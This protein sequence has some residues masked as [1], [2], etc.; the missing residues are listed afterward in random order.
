MPSHM[1]GPL[2]NLI[3][4]KM[5]SCKKQYNIIND[6]HNFKQLKEF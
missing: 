6:N 1:L 2:K 4:R 5:K 3:K